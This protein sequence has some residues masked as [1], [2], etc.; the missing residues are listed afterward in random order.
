MSSSLRRT[1]ELGLRGVAL[2]ALTWLV[3]R[4]ARP[5]ADGRATRSA[6]SGAALPAALARWSSFEDAESLHVSFDTL[7]SAR[8]RDW[9][10]ALRRSGRSVG[11]DGRA[12]PPIAVAAEPEARP[13]GGARVL[14][15]APAAASV[16]VGDAAGTLDSL[17]VAPAGGRGVV[18]ASARLAE[19]AVATVSGSRARAPIPD[20]ARAGRVL[21]LGAAG[22]E[23]KFVIAA[24]EEDGW[25]VDARLRVSPT[26]EVSQ[27][28]SATPDTARHAAAVVLD[29]AAAIANA[30]ALVRFVR[31]GGGVVV[32][33]DAAR[34]AALRDI[35]PAGAAGT[36]VAGVAGAFDTDSARRALTL[37]PL[38]RLARDAIVL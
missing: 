17:R 22:W 10:L 8:T 1:I 16:S 5:P 20:Q 32:A 23:A 12:L 31:Q 24:L 18:L 13:R 9:L 7:P 26:V 35:A 4:T 11:W 3:W 27:G 2:A 29:S 19:A 34:V 36:A 33:G 30:T 38:E 15:A 37:L 6:A 25:Q 14:A 21:V 28:G